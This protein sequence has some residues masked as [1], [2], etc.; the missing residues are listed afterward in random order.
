M[1]TPCPICGRFLSSL[2]RHRKACER[3]M[4]KLRDAV[5]LL[6]SAEKIR[7][8][9]ADANSMPGALARGTQAAQR[10]DELIT[11]AE[12]RELIVVRCAKAVFA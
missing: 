3:R 9:F 8:K 11:E 12:L 5:L 2:G 7:D 6:R 10:L 4:A 1:T